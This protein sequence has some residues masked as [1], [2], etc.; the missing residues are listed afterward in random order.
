MVDYRGLGALNAV[1]PTAFAGAPGGLVI[2]EGPDGSLE[3]DSVLRGVVQGAV[4][5]EALRDALSELLFF[6]LYQ[7]TE[8]LGRRRGDDLARRVKMIHNMLALGPGTSAS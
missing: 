6:V 3:E 7:A 8:L 4:P 2:P 1:T 5:A